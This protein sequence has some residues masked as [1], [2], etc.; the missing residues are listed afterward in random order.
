[1]THGLI[2]WNPETGL[3]RGRMDQV[4][5]QMLRDFWN[6]TPS[7]ATGNRAWMPAV[8]IREEADALVLTAELPGLTKDQ[9]DVTLE[10]NVLTIAGERKFDNEQLEATYHRIERSYGAF[11]RSFTLPS[12]VHTDKVDA[13]FT[14]GVLTVRLPKQEASK[15]R[16]VMVR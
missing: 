8:D 15:A 6:P 14:D 3:L 16:K 1:M 13:T 12:T 10:N 9:V 7:E 2:R 5:N 11:S 4:F